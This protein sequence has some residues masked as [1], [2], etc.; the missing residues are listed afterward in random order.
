MN[1]LSTTLAFLIDHDIYVEERCIEFM[2]R[3]LIAEQPAVVCPRIRLLPESD[4]VQVE[5]AALHFLGTLILRH[6][7]Q[8]V[9]CTPAAAGYVDGSTGGC[10]LVQ[11]QRIIDAGGFDELF[12]FY[13]EDLEFSLRLRARGLRFWC[14]PAA[15]V[16][17]EPAAGTP[18]L[19]FRGKGQYPPRRAYLTMRNRLLTILIHYRMRTLLVLMPVLLLYEIAAVVAALRKQCASQWLR[20][21]LWQF[22]N[23]RTI[24]ARRRRSQSIR[25]IDDRELLVGGELPLAPGFL[26]SRLEARLLRW[27]SNVA[28]AYW[29]LAR[30]W[31]G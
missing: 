5:G 24:V 18:G 26:V 28:N 10:M 14:E 21:W 2:V 12:F 20:A 23:L 9:E 11:R 16:F 30:N 15:E 6:A 7:Y 3:A 4:I 1:A 17:H 31:I 27:F 8:P 19:S 22:R 29:S 25:I 13:F